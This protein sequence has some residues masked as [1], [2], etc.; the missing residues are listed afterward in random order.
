MIMFSFV[1]ADYK[2]SVF[3]PDRNIYLSFVYSDELGKHFLYMESY[4]G[5]EKILPFDRFQV[6]GIR[7]SFYNYRALPYKRQSSINKLDKRVPS[8]RANSFGFPW[9]DGHKELK[10]I[11]GFY[12]RIRKQYAVIAHTRLPLHEDPEKV[13]LIFDRYSDAISLILDYGYSEIKSLLGSNFKIFNVLY[14][15]LLV[16]HMHHPICLFSNVGSY[17]G[18][19]SLGPDWCCCLVCF[20][21]GDFDQGSLTRSVFGF[22]HKDSF[23]RVIHCDD[24]L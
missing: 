16:D 24:R 14:P 1:E 2:D 6:Y 15:Y 18:S 23:S 21:R 20:L 10:K 13:L 12:S 4:N 9:Y 19:H 8:L 17:R 5:K 7:P 11:K 22:I 3:L